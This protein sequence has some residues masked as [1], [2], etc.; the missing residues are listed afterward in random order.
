MLKTQ[1]SEL[2]PKPQAGD[3]G[4]AVHPTRQVILGDIGVQ[5]TQALTGPYRT[6]Q[7]PKILTVTQA[8]PPRHQVDL[9][10]GSDPPQVQ[11]CLP[12][13]PGGGK[14]AVLVC[15]RGQ[16]P[17]PSNCILDPRAGVQS[18]HPTSHPVAQ[19]HVPAGWLSPQLQTCLLISP[20][21]QA[22]HLFVPMGLGCTEHLGEFMVLGRAGNLGA[23][24][25]SWLQYLGGQ[26]PRA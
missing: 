9:R 19:P 13:V 3:P 18:G 14:Y 17:S 2:H 7:N 5:E 12:L 21:P 11:G 16:S 10:W 4:I 26:N 23:P 1:V 20:H 15:L 22:P 6:D 8:S 24:L 25:N